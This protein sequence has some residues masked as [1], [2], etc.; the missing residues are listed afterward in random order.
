MRR[1]A[2]TLLLAPFVALAG[3]AFFAPSARA[4]APAT[5]PPTA[6]IAS[7]PESDAA[8]DASQLPPVDVL[9]VS[10]IFDK[11]VVRS[12]V[13]AIEHSEAAGSEALILQLTSRGAVVSDAEMT[14]LLQRVA[15]AKVPIGIWVGPSRGSRAYG[16]PAQ[17]LAV[18]DVTAMVGGS[19][20]GHISSPLIVDGEPISFGPATE[21]LIDGTM[22]FNE[23]R[24]AGA[25][26]LDTTDQGVPTV[27]NMILAMDGKTIDGRLVNT[28]VKQLND[29]GEEENV[30][31]VPVFSGLGLVD[32]V[33]H[34]VASPPMAF[35]LFII[36]LALLVFE[37][38]T[39]GV[40]IAGGVGAVCAVLGCYG[41]SAL[42]A[43]PVAVGLLVLSMLAFAVDVQVGIPRT[44]TG[45]GIVLFIF[46]AW[47]LYEPVPGN[48]L[49]LGWITL[50]VGVAGVMLTF[51][52]GMPS[53]VRTRFAT[54]TIGR[55][56]MI[57]HDG[58]ATTT[59]DPDGVA[60]VGGARWRARTNR[61]TPI[62]AGANLKVV[63]IDGVTLEVEPEEGAARDYRERRVKQ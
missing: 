25:L 9:Q 48:S 1:L 6:P 57:G 15:D 34:T 38:F 53:M 52:V 21:E 35:L 44:W 11:I 23:A 3:I 17:L 16:L 4:F 49:R 56:W 58:T 10:G 29:K 24:A 7:E 27:R 5:T 26:K 37:F 33:M 46:G 50:V 36:G 42:P 13:K 30:S 62:K 8:T 51:I 31:T 40:G 45:V 22:S 32:E 18:A 55:E 54:P 60:M 39:A 59:I 47:Y 28:V 19:R 63:A 12:I 43:R 14:R 41:L 20:I 2:I 61:A